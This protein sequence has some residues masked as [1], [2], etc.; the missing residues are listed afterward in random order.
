MLYYCERNEARGPKVSLWSEREAPSACINVSESST[1]H[2]ILE[3]GRRAFEYKPIFLFLCPESIYK[4][5]TELIL[6]PHALKLLMNFFQ[7]IVG[8]GHLL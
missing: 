7:W 4:V 8:E 1:E 2:T 6:V 5:D 3:N